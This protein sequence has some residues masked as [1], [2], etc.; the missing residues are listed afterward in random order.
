MPE[1][2]SIVELILNAS[3]VVQVVMAALG[4][5]SIISWGMIFQRWFYLR[6]VVA[7]VDEFEDHFWSGIDLQKFAKDKQN[8]E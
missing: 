8:V 4:L 5:A 2:L 1:Q 6:S 7:S 3:L